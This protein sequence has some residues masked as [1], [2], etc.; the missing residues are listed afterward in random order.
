MEG[1]YKPLSIVRK[2]SYLT[3]IKPLFNVF[4]SSAYSAR[5]LV[6]LT[7]LFIYFSL[8]AKPLQKEADTAIQ[9]D[10]SLLQSL[11]L[12]KRTAKLEQERITANYQSHSLILDQSKKF[13][14]LSLE[15]QNTRHYLNQGFEYKKVLDLIEQVKAWKEIAIDGVIVN[16]DSLQTNRNLTATS[17]LLKELVSRKNI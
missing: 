2:V 8:P 16:K 11:G 17:I 6:T 5:G 3:F 10:T 1:V 9:S 4:Y 13:I 12:I 15:I 14:A 7:F